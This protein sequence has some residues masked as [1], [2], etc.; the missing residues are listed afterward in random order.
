[1][2]KTFVSASIL[3][4]V[5]QGKIS[6][7]DPL[8]KWVPGVPNTTGVT[9]MMLLDH[10]S[11]IYNYTDDPSFDP[12]KPW[13]PQQ[14][15]ALAAMHAP[16]FAP[17]A[18]FHYSNT[19]YV[20]LGMILEAATGQ[21]AGA[22]LHARAIDPAKLTGTFFDGFDAI[23]PAR[24]ARGFHLGTDVTFYDDP[25]VSWT[26][27]AMV[28]D[29]AS[30]AQWMATLYGTDAVLDANGRALLTSKTSD[31]GNGVSYGLGVILFDASI[32]G[33]GGPAM[34]HDGAI[35]G[36]QSQAFWFPQK[37][38]AVVSIVNDDT[39]DPNAVSVAALQK[40]F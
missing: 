7:S 3:S 31:L 11:G 8:S 1:V 29:G 22:A 30:L 2:T 36:F 23:D 20:L 34:G 15:V 12:T 24:M 25:S 9:V 32:T 38:T 17:D 35:A 40:L 4:L 33:G 10:R 13:T 19:N 5:E 28:S 18:D 37:Q 21:K 27:G 26:A 16:Y 39:G 14:I 6:L